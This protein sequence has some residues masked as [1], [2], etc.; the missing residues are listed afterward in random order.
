MRISLLKDAF[1]ASGRAYHVRARAVAMFAAFN[2]VTINIQ[3]V[4]CTRLSCGPD[5]HN[6]QRNHIIPRTNAAAAAVPSWFKEQMYNRTRLPSFVVYGEKKSVSLNFLPF[7]K[8]TC[9]FFFS[10]AWVF[11]RLYTHICWYFVFLD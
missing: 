3:L 9:L 2:A 5:G 11:T 10:R 7:M 6:I 1:K 4:C 8:C